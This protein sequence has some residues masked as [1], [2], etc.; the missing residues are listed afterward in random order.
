MTKGRWDVLVGLRNFKAA[1]SDIQK[2]LHQF[3]TQVPI[4][5]ATL[6]VQWKKW[7]EDFLGDNDSSKG[8]NS[9]TTTSANT[10]AS[11]VT[12][13][14][15]ENDSVKNGMEFE[16]TVV[17]NDHASKIQIAPAT[18]DMEEEMTKLRILIRKQDAMIASQEA[19][20]K[21]LTEK[22]EKLEGN[23]PEVKE[24]KEHEENQED[25]MQVETEEKP[26]RVTALEDQMSRMMAMMSRFLDEKEK[27]NQQD[28]DSNKR[29]QQDE[30][31]DASA[32][33][34]ANK[35]ANQNSTP[36]KSPSLAKAMQFQNP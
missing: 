17:K 29:N 27:D 10:Y 22:M 13:G 15:R 2:I 21:S 1:K 33:E 30:T 25:Q 7:N 6:P 9:F 4:D 12:D 20:M 23:K 32:L 11:M 28:K 16:M 18:N 8:D 3:E 19:M 31:T 24:E 34:S 26:D 35:K 36:K 14:D 5:K